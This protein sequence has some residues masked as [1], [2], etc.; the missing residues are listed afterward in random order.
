MAF[1]RIIPNLLLK[2]GEF[3]TSYKFRKLLYIGDSA[4]I[5]N[6]FNKKCIDELVITPVSY[7]N[8]KSLIDDIRQISKF[9]F[10]PLSINGALHDL[11]SVKTLLDSGVERVFF[12]RSIFTHNNSLIESVATLYGT[13]AVGISLVIK[14]TLLKGVYKFYNNSLRKFLSDDENFN[15]TSLLSRK[16]H[17][18]ILITNLTKDGTYNGFGEY[19]ILQKF[20]KEKVIVSGGVSSYEEIQE[21]LEIESVSAVAASSLFAYAGLNQGVL[22]NYP[23]EKSIERKRSSCL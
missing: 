4:N 5:L 11:F 18:E 17:S 15:L 12:H 20:T 21:L 16:L 22:I 2:D 8:E 13:Q 3:Y 6:I 23:N 10:V 9:C 1:K 14:R 19:D 7:V